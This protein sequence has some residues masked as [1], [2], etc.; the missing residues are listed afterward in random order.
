MGR[1]LLLDQRRL[2][3]LARLGGEISGQPFPPGSSYYRKDKGCMLGSKRSR[4]IGRVSHRGCGY[5]EWRVVPTVSP[6]DQLTAVDREGGEKR[7]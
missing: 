2:G 7:Y 1:P 6:G 4:V 3:E 5:R